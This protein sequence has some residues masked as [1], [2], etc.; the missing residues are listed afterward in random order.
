M[1]SSSQ[2]H[3]NHRKR[4]RER[5]K[6]D[7]VTALADHELLEMFLFDV[8]PRRNTNPTAHLL[9]E[10]FGSLD[11]V[12]S[13][14]VEELLEVEGIGEVTARYIVDSRIAYVEKCESEMLSRP[15]RSLEL[16]SNYLIFHRS[17]SDTSFTVLI[18]SSEMEVLRVADVTS[19]EDVY[20]CDGESER[21][22]IAAAPEVIREA[23]EISLTKSE[24]VDV[25][26]VDGFTVKSIIRFPEK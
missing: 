7:G 18:L 5:V 3:S 26:S 25:L 2:I 15:F 24:L 22:I 17:H 4:M 11:K 21:I 12:L 20:A 6:S 13:A 23:C 10:R 14:S 19:L 9:F 16:V 1:E 8:I